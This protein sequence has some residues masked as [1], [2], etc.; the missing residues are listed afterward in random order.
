[1][2]TKMFDPYWN[3]TES[4]EA[5]KIYLDMNFDGL[6]ESILSLPANERVRI[7]TGTF[8]ND[9]TTLNRADDVMTLLVHLGYLGYDFGMKEVFIP[10]REITQEYVNAL[11]GNTGWKEVI[12]SVKAFDRLLH[13]TLEEKADMVANGIEKA[14]AALFRCE[15]HYETYRHPSQNHPPS[16]R[17]VSCPCP[18][19]SLA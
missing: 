17:V 5:L 18:Q 6:R 9:M 7:D 12:E 19:A 16:D 13:A 15:V 11:A 8:S 1:M 3:R 10:N 2:T 14:H 4:Y